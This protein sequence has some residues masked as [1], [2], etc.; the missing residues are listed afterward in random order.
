MTNFY[1]SLRCGAA[2]LVIAAAALTSVAHPRAEVPQ[3]IAVANVK[4][5]AKFHG[6][7]AQIYECGM[8]AHGNNTWRFREPVAVLMMEGQTVGRHFTGP[9]WELIDGS[10]VGGEIVGRQPGATPNDIPLLKL[11]VTTQNNVGRLSEVT[12]IQRLNTSGGVLEGP[13]SS[14]GTLRSVPYAADYTFLKPAH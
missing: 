2:V 6:E 4:L 11:K 13:C 8:D 12:V 7:G 14:P 9:R 5:V 3:V 10:V 1:G